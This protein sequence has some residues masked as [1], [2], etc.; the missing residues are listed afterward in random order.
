M[1]KIS[2]NVNKIFDEKVRPVGKSKV[3]S[4]NRNYMRGGGD[5]EVISSLCFSFIEE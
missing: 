3:D 2:L 5:V 1:K 4:F